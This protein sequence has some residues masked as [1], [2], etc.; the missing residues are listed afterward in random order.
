MTSVL[1][2][3]EITVAKIPAGTDTLLD[4]TLQRPNFTKVSVDIKIARMARDLRNHYLNRPEQYK[5]KTLSVPDSIH[6]ATAIV[7]RANEFH[8]FDE[9][10]GNRD[11]TLGLIPLSGDV[12]GHNLIIR[13]PPQ[14]EGTM[15]LWQA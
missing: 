14:A 13:K 12:A 15:S 7:Y 6:L 9:K 2:I 8:T 5:G 4:T 11:K 3:T 10:D 1:T